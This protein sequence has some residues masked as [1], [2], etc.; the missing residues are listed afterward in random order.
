VTNNHVRPLA[1]RAVSSVFTLFLNVLF[2][3]SLKYYNGPCLLRTRLVKSVPLRSDGFG[4]AAA[5]L[6]LLLKG[7]ASYREIGIPLVYRP[8]GRSNAVTWKNITSV[9]QL[10]W[11]LARAAR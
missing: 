6:V 7:G 5:V 9:F 8:F 3:L 2:G 4:Y 1:R 11:R 10:L